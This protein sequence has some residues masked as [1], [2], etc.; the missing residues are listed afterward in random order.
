MTEADSTAATLL[1][2][3]LCAS[4]AHRRYLNRTSEPVTDRVMR[5]YAATCFAFL[6]FLVASMALGTVVQWSSPYVVWEST[7]TGEPVPSPSPGSPPTIGR[8]GTIE[9]RGSTGG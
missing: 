3:F 8:D 6:G 7:R 5:A 4:W 1:A 2:A 9:D